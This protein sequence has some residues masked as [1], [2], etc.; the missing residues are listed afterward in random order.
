[1][2]D[3][4]ETGLVFT[5]SRKETEEPFTTSEVIAKYANIELKSVNQLIRRYRKEITSLGIS[6]F[7]M[8]KLNNGLVGRPMTVYYLNEQQASFLITLLKNTEKVVQFKYKLTKAFFET[9]KDLQKRKLEHAQSK[10]ITK[11]LGEAIK[12]NPM[13]N[14][15]HD[16][17][18]FNKLIYK[19]ALG[20]NTNQLRINRGIPKEANII[21]YLSLEEQQKVTN[22]KNVVISLLNMNLDYQTV[23]KT[24]SGIEITLNDK[25]G[26]KKSP[27]LCRVMD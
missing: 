27:S 3:L 16:Y 24:L 2:Y 7:K 21:D 9:S 1:M 6:T 22:I 26:Y 10:V 13:T 4:L 20:L 15:C 25:K 23:K 17:S 18:N 14:S 5:N 11:S 8:S 19:H 12:N